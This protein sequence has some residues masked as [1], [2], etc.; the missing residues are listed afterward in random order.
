MTAV[1]VRVFQNKKHIALS[2]SARTW[3]CCFY[4]CTNKM[5]RRFFYEEGEKNRIFGHTAGF[6]GF[7]ANLQKGA[8]RVYGAMINDIRAI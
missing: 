6:K 8:R 5:L 2:R 3:F 4:C 7:P 1:A